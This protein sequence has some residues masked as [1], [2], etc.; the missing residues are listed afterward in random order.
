MYGSS[1][2][3]GLSVVTS[4]VYTTTF[5]VLVAF[6]R[7]RLTVPRNVRFGYASTVN[8]DR[9]A[10]V[11]L[12]DVGLV[13][14][15]PHLHPV[16]VLGDQEQAGGVERRLHGLA[17]GHAA[18][19]DRPLD[20]RLDGAVAEV[21]LVLLEGGLGGVDGR[22]GDP[23]GGLGRRSPPLASTSAA[24]GWASAPRPTPDRG[25]VAVDAASAASYSGLRDRPGVPE[26]LGPLPVPVRSGR[27]W[28]WPAG[29]RPRPADV[30][31][32]AW[33]TRPWPVHL[34][35]DRAE[36]LLRRFAGRGLID[37]GPVRA[38]RRSGRGR[39]P[40]STGEP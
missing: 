11:D 1:L 15:R 28:P 21:D 36:L 26:A 25:A 34:A 29:G 19:D 23:D 22:L 33:S 7:T 37:P 39:C 3:S 9:L 12:A 27:T 20:R 6:S 16:Q 17:E 8:C 32:L 5:C 40:G 35:F 38:S 2:P 14:R 30:F 13:H 18:V 24:A 10:D 4:T 31:A